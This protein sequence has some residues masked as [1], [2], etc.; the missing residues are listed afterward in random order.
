MLRAQR[1]E[2]VDPQALI[3]QYQNEIADLRALLREKGLDG[4][5]PSGSASGGV[6]GKES[7]QAMEK[8]LEELK[9]LILT[10]NNVPS[11]SDVE[12]SKP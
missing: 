5:M 12:V 4:A 10:S 7:N 6:K 9:S 3:A 1:K 8:R 11:S 2:L